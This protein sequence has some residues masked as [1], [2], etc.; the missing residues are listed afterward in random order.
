MWSASGKRSKGL[1]R[2]FRVYRRGLGVKGFGWSSAEQHIVQC[3]ER[4]RSKAAPRK[5]HLFNAEGHLHSA[6]C[7]QNGTC[8]APKLGGF[9]FYVV[10]QKLLP[11]SSFGGSKESKNTSPITSALSTC[12]VS[13]TRKYCHASQMIEKPKVSAHIIS[14]LPLQAL[15]LN[16]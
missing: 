8:P 12:T 1:V 6:R 4:E 7:T 13:E 3:G 16:R 15:L 11:S 2:F 5:R 14:A 9:R 10:L